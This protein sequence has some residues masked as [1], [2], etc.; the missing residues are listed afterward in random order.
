[1]SKNKKS[2]KTKT[3][4]LPP[5]VLVDVNSNCNLQCPQCLVHGNSEDPRAIRY[6]NKVM[7]LEKAK[8]IVDEIAQ[9]PPLLI[10][11][12]WSEPL[13][14]PYFYELAQYMK[15]KGLTLS[16]NTNGLLLNEKMAHFLVNLEFD[17]VIISLD[18][19]TDET[20]KKIRGIS[21][22]SPLKKIVERLVRIRGDRKK[23]RIGVSMTLQEANLHERDAFVTYWTKKVDFVRISTYF[24]GE[25]LIYSDSKKMSRRIPCPSLYSTMAIHADGNVSI[26]CLDIFNEYN[27]GNVF[28]EGVGGVWD[29]E[30]FNHIRELHEKNDYSELPLCRKCSRWNSYQYEDR[31]EN[32]LLIRKS[33]EFEYYNRIDRLDNWDEQLHGTHTEWEEMLK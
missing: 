16:I 25:D 27:M 30:K 11:S 31:I 7:P 10:P 33:S 17:S 1:M 4:A 9:R 19:T 24:N 28:T 29:G 32:G 12:L 21:R 6:K 13:F 15:E 18:A 3:P 8:S 23:P 2:K 5:R 26:C 14:Y 22:I 20:L